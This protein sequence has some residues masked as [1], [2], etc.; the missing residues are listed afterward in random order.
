[1]MLT[2]DLAVLSPTCL[3]VCLSVSFFLSIALLSKELCDLIIIV[4]TNRQQKCGLFGK[5]RLQRISKVVK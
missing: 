4:E 2:S 1:M 3:S 5:E